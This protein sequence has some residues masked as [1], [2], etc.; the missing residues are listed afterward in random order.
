MMSSAALPNVAFK[1]PP[2][3]APSRDA[4][5]SVAS[6]M[7][8]ANGTIASPLSTNTAS[9]LACIH[10]AIGASATQT[11]SRR[12]QCCGPK[13]RAAVAGGEACMRSQSGGGAALVQ[14]L[15]ERTAVR[16][17]AKFDAFAPR[18]LGCARF[19]GDR[20]VSVIKYLGSKRRLVPLL[21]RTIASLGAH[22]ALDLFS[23]TA[24]V[25]MALKEQGLRV[26]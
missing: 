21:A 9:A 24:R 14:F 15:A 18:R 6:P 7:S 22:T 11:S 25:G 1:S 19:D 13:P 16:V 2:T 5:R 17:T 23:G 3:P 4:I 8:P 20:E 12:S 10:S 26:H